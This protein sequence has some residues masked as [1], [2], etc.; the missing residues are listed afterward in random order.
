MIARV[1]FSEKYNAIAAELNKI[2]CRS[3]L[4]GT[5]TG[6]DALGAI[7]V[8]QMTATSMG[9]PIPNRILTSRLVSK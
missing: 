6:M 1:P 3:I 7:N 4:I 2:I 5:E 8:P 9:V